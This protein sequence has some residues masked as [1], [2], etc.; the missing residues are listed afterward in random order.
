VV[1][2]EVWGDHSA[3]IQYGFFP[4]PA[5]N[6]L[7]R[8]IAGLYYANYIRFFVFTFGN[9]LLK[10][11]MK[12]FEE[13]CVIIPGLEDSLKNRISFFLSDLINGNAIIALLIII[14]VQGTA[15]FKA[16]TVAV[17]SINVAL[18]YMMPP[19]T[20]V[21]PMRRRDYSGMVIYPSLFAYDYCFGPS[22]ITDYIKVA[23]ADLL[24]NWRCFYL[25]VMY[26]VVI[27]IIVFCWMVT[28]AIVSMKAC[29]DAPCRFVLCI[30]LLVLKVICFALDILT[31]REFY[32]DPLSTMA[33]CIEFHVIP[34]EQLKSYPEVVLFLSD[35]VLQDLKDDTLMAMAAPIR[36]SQHVELSSAAD[37]PNP[38]V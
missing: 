37:Q 27:L 2:G 18:T 31:M 19:H 36:E 16:Y 38:R 13:R 14:G 32:L 15:T 11:R 6:M 12:R 17:Q 25:W 5:D 10:Q 30:W 4:G 21:G 1:V 29:C 34:P 22:G 35:D 3:G 33:L 26:W 9:D 23:V 28:M 7:S 20:V 24:L 8:E